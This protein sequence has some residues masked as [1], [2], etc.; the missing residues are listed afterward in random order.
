MQFKS[1]QEFTLVN[2]TMV[3]FPS[4]KQMILDSSIHV[5]VQG[6]AII[7]P[8][9]FAFRSLFITI[10]FHANRLFAAKPN[11]DLKHTS[12]IPSAF[13]TLGLFAQS[14]DIAWYISCK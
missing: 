9:P 3:S 2:Q 14:C 8:N 13:L 5:A 12:R 6:R 10:K 11:K 7:T 1:N 4:K